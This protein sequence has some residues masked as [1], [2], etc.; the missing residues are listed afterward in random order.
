LAGA[1]P[2]TPLGELTTLPTPQL[3]LRGLLLREQGRRD[4]R[5][6]QG[7]GGDLTS[8]ARREKGEVKGKERVSPQT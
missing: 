5:E 7:K 3:D 1:S 4:G 8:K 2:Q 6:G